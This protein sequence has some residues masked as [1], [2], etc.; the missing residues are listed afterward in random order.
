MKRIVLLVMI[1][2]SVV[3]TKAQEVNKPKITAQDLANRAGDHFMFQITR[4][5][6][7]NMPDSINSHQKGFSKG[8]NVYIMTDKPFRT[9]PQFSV[10]LGIGYGTSNIKF[11][12]MQV[13]VKSASTTLPFRALDSTD[14]FKKY[15]VSLGYL[16]VPVEL[17]FSSKPLNSS[18]SFKI[19]LGGKV[20]TL[21]NAHTKGKDLQNKNNSTINAFSQKENSKRFFNTTRLSTTARIGYG[22]FSIYG[23]YQITSVLKDA[24]GPDMKLVQIG[25]SI[26]GL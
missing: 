2:T 26:G 9:S 3:F 10:A 20:G 6:W 1:M 18:K 23:S 5:S 19:A 21:L 17:R 11:E 14:H 12:K 15:K 4:D 25:L 16:E 22:I 13:D 8:F 7:T 24:A